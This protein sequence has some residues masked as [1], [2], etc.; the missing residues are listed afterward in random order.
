MIKIYNQQL[1]LVAKVENAYGIGYDKNFN[2]VNWAEFSLPINDPKNLLCKAFNFVEVIDKDN[3]IGMFQIVPKLTSKTNKEIRYTLRHAIG[4]LLGDVLFR[5]HQTVNLTTRENIQFILDQQSTRHWVLGVCEF[6][7]YFHYKYENENGLLGPLFAIPKPFD[8]EYEWTYNTQVYPFELNL[9]A[10]STEVSCIIQEAHNQIGIEKDE[11]NEIVNRIY[12]L[13]YGE[14]VNQLGIEKV[15]NGIPYLEDAAS[16]AK[17]GLQSY[18]W[19]DKKFE[20]PNTLKANAAALLKKWANSPPAYR[21]KAADVSSITKEDIHKL[22]CGRIVRV[23]DSDLG[24]FDLRIMS[25]KKGDIIGAPGE[26]DLNVGSLT[27]DMATTLTDLQRKIQINEA[28]SQGSASQDTRTYADNCDEN[29][30]AIIEFPVDPDC[31]YV[32]KVILKY[33]TEKFRGY[34]R[35]MKSAGQVVKSVTSSNAGEHVSTETSS[36][37][38]GY[39]NSVTSS[40]GG[41]SLETSDDKTFITWTAVSS[42]VMNP[43]GQYEDHY[44]ETTLQGNWFTHNHKFNVPNHSHNVNLNIPSHSHNINLNIPGHSHQMSINIPGHTHE[45]E[46]GIWEA[47]VTPSNVAIYVDD[48]LVTGVASLE[49]EIDIV[50]YLSKDSS[51]NINRNYHTVKIVPNDIGR[52]V[53]NVSIQQFIQSRGSYKK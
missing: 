53:A 18:V 22:K 12:P 32:N 25:E 17:H 43:L 37:G 9:V 2:E 41:G 13:G 1:Q 33:K 23:K 4:T 20:D 28:Y 24:T 6:T 3:Y 8:V 11:Q 19:V 36:S 27:S 40:S 51:G 29:F 15:N 42:N 7:R 5:Y 44:H 47:A 34:T 30:P 14:G 46:Y 10:P 21:V 38:G 35:G 49:G 16:I 50:P 52:V 31:V 48:Q 26:V 45:N 39:T